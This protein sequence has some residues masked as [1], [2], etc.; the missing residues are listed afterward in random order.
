MGGHSGATDC[1]ELDEPAA[2][3]AA[4]AATRLN[5]SIFFP[6]AADA[7]SAVR[8]VGSGGRGTSGELASAAAPVIAAASKANFM[9]SIW[10]ELYRLVAKSIKYK[11]M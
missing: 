6:A 5:F 3:P 4:R 11:Y 9:P 1:A 8:L 10:L 2:M 7:T